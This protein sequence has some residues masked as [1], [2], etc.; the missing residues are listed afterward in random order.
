MRPSTMALVVLV[1]ATT[2][3][4]AQAVMHNHIF[5]WYEFKRAEAARVRRPASGEEFR[6]MMPGDGTS[7]QSEDDT[8]VDPVEAAVPFDVDRDALPVEAQPLHTRLG[9]MYV[10]YNQKTGKWRFCRGDP[11]KAEDRVRW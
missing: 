3:C 9:W 10:C 2:M 8:E 1:M 11:S 4:L 6:V 5:P 7:P